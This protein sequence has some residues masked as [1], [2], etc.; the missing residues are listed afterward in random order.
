MMYT[1]R[2][3]LIVA[4]DFVTC[5]ATLTLNR[6]LIAVLWLSKQGFFRESKQ[7]VDSQ[8][9]D[10]TCCLRDVKLLL[11]V[12][13][14]LLI[15][16]TW[17]PGGSLGSSTRTIGPGTGPDLPCLV[18]LIEAL[19]NHYHTRD[20]LTKTRADHLMPQKHVQG[21]SSWANSGNNS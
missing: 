4:A 9:G 6:T 8:T 12:Q 7:R 18:V 19:W 10:S 2:E 16:P 13:G 17:T 15:A 1:I 11:Y 21:P 20:P 14:G 3:L 5:E